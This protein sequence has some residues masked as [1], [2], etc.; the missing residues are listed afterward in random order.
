VNVDLSSLGQVN[1]GIATL[2]LMK[3]GSGGLFVLIAKKEY[4]SN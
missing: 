3:K 2:I 1:L 4:K